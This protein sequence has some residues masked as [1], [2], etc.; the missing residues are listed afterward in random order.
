MELKQINLG[1]VISL[2]DIRNTDL[3]VSLLLGVSNEK[4][5]IPSIANINGTDLSKYKIL[6][7]N[8]FVYVP[9]TSRNGDKVSIAILK[10]A[11]ACI[12]SSSYT[13]FEVYNTKLIIPDYLMLFFS[14]SEFDRYG[15]Y[16]SWGTAREVLSW[17]D[18][19]S[20]EINVPSIE[21]QQ[22]IV[23]QY[24]SISERISLL[25]RMIS[26][27]EELIFCNYLSLI[28]NRSN[29][30]VIENL[31]IISEKSKIQVGQ[32]SNDSD[33]LYPFF[34]C[35]DSILLHNKKLVEGKNL[36]LSTGGKFDVKYLDGEAS[37]STDILCLRGAS[38]F[39]TYYLYCLLKYN[40]SYIN[41][42]FFEGTALQ[43]LKKK[44][45]FNWG[46]YI[47]NVEEINIFGKN[48]EPLF[49]YVTLLNKEIDNLVKLQKLLIQKM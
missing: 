47:P 35:G 4:K 21:E 10:E 19:C 2:T 33:K 29:N 9:T 49:K 41:D 12:V 3:S 34:R 27:T 25:N 36:Y 23:N 46:I 8:Q 6:K 31:I 24:S 18:L 11:D 1:D 43:H 48:I 13:T 45:F 37:Y 28:E 7:K 42:L 38:D 22:K 17:E 30:G 5:I 16:N 15:R 32:I 20:M 40:T 44:E 39:Y 26:K 14:T